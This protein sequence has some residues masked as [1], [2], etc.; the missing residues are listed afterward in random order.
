MIPDTAIRNGQ[1]QV[2]MKHLKLAPVRVKCSDYT[3][4]FVIQANIPMAWISPEHVPCVQKL[5]MRCCGDSRR[6]KKSAVIFAHEADVRQ[7]TNKGGR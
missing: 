2:A 4:I 6:G 5:R 1:G 3:Y 7:W